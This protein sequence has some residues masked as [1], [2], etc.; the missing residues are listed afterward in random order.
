ML[1]KERGG[2][3]KV[4]WNVWEHAALFRNIWGGK[5]VR[6]KIFEHFVFFIRE[7]IIL[8]T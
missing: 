4:G 2:K 5:L 1:L 3:F 7:I 6:K 8:H